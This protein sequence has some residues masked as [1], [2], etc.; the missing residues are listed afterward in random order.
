MALSRLQDD[1]LQD[2]NEQKL[3]IESQLEVFDPMG[4]E[5]S[6]PAAQRLVSKGALI[7]AEI[8]CYLLSL[9]CIAFAVFLTKLFPFFIL[10]EIRFKSQYN[11]LGAVNVE[12]FNLAIYGLIG[13]ICILFYFL[14]RAMHSIRQKNN[15][16]H[17]A[18]KHIKTL[19]SQHLKRKANIQALEQR[20]FMDQPIT[21]P[22]EVRVND[23]PNPGYDGNNL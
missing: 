17:F 1:L 14:A 11:A 3:M 22:H 18:G 19:V 12:A 4:V 7:F 16:L 2:F 5:L 23:V 13:I 21:M 20:H 10:S 9:G 6:K 8:C 15:I